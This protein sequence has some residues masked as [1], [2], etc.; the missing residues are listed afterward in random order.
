MHNKKRIRIQKKGFIE[1]LFIALNPLILSFSF[2]LHTWSL[3]AH[4]PKQSPFFF[5][6]SPRKAIDERVFAGQK[7][8][9]YDVMIH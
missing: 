6:L 5:R 9:F 4:V 1:G 8:G 7:K 2:F 3:F